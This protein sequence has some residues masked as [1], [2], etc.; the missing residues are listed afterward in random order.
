MAVA[1]EQIITMR[2][3]IAESTADTYTDQMIVAAIEARPVKDTR[4]VDWYEWD[5]TTTPPTQDENPNWIP[6]YDMR[7][8]AADIWDEKAAAVA[9]D[10]SFSADGASYQRQQVFDQYTRIAAK[11]RSRARIGS[12]KMVSKTR[13]LREDGVVLESSNIV[14]QYDRSDVVNE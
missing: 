11:Y 5:F 6:T 12:V 8:A 10:F 13:E 4:G 3:M 1:A 14:D 7:T 9:C 2:R